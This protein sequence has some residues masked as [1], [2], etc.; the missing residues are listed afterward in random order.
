MDNLLKIQA[1]AAPVRMQVVSVLQQAIESGRFAPGDRLIER[2]LCDLTGVSRTSVREALRELESRGLVQ[3]VPNR[4]PIVAV[5]TPQEARDLYEVRAALEGLAGEL[6]AVRAS[7]VQVRQLRAKVNEIKRQARNGEI[8]N[9]PLVK[10]GF[11]E[12]L[13]E[14]AGNS[15]A[16]SM[17][18]GI[19]SRITILR[20]TTLSRP[21]RAIVMAS[22]LDEIMDAIEAREPEATRKACVRHIRMAATVALEILSEDDETF[23]AER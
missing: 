2:E 18:D 13:F 16:K 5:L 17:L 4:G 15:G 3:M 6:F 20:R 1:T 14:G 10:D 11:Y 8:V 21:D 7:D 12:L 23:A 22:E 19:H 9:L